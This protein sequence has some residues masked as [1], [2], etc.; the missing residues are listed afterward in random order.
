MPAKRNVRLWTYA[1]AG[2]GGA[3]ALECLPFLLFGHAT[4][5]PFPSAARILQLTIVMTLAVA[6][7]V[8][9]AILYFRNSDEFTQ[10]G[11]RVAWYWGGVMGIAASAPVFTFVEAGGLHWLWPSTPVGPELAR[12]F[13]MGYALPVV[14]Q[15]AGFFIVAAWWQLS[16]R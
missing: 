9:F 7:G 14:T 10:E 12:A 16:K 11:S 13:A 4:P 8:A 1:V 6:W 15:L 3:L 5:P 2:L